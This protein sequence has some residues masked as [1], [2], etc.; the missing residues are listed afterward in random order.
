[1][2]KTPV[3]GYTNLYLDGLQTNQ[4][5]VLTAQTLAGGD[6]TL[7]NDQM[8]N[9]RIEVTTGHAANV[10]IVPATDYAGK[11][12]VIANNDAA[13]AAG[14]KVAGGTAVSVAATKTAIVQVNGAGTEVKR[15]TADA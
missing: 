5:G 8:V 2:A 14:I 9:G 4:T 11:I 3:S 1:M 10:F 13:L 15:V 7:T 12:I 6:V